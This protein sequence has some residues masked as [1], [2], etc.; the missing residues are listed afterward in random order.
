[1]L[2]F[3]RYQLLALLAVVGTGK[4]LLSLRCDAFIITKSLCGFLE[5]K[6]FSIR[7]FFLFINTKNFLFQK[8]NDKCERSFK[9]GFIK[10]EK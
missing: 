6:F 4:V 2:I 1:M 9:K 5:V 8:E 10:I 7:N 3:H